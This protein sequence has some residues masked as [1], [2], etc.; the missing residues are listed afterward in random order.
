MSDFENEIEKSRRQERR[1]KAKAPKHD[2]FE[3]SGR[4]GKANSHQ[5]YDESDDPDII[6]GKVTDVSDEMIL[7]IKVIRQ[8]Y[9]NRYT[10]QPTEKVRCIS[11]ADLDSPDELREELLDQRI[12]CE[13]HGRERGNVLLVTYDKND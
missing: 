10:Y 8:E 2:D 11:S 6:L 5:D 12:S 1:A 9:S 13:I 4:R 3:P 7:T